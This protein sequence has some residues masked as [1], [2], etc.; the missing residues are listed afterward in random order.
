MF[1]VESGGGTSNPGFSSTRGIHIHTGKFSQVAHDAVSSTA[2]IGTGLFWDTVYERLQE[3]G[4]SV[5]GGR[6]ARVSPCDPYVR[7]ISTPSRDRLD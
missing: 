2:V 4:V 1:Q 6:T 7:V 3:R 5:V